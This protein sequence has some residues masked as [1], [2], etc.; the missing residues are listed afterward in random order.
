MRLTLLAAGAAAFLVTVYRAATYPFTHDESLSYGMLTWAPEW[1]STANNHPLN[2]LL[3]RACAAL[4]GSSE[5]SLRLPNVL[6]LLLY[7]TAAVLLLRR[8]EH[9]LPQL[10]GF[11]LLV[12]NPF[13]LDFFAV[14]RG[15]GLALGFL[16]ASVWL[17]VRGLEGDAWS[18]YLCVPAGALS[19]IAN[20]TFLNFFAPLLAVA[21][22]I[23]VRRK[24]FPGAIVITCAGALFLA[25]TGLEV[26]SMQQRGVLAFGGDQGIVADTLASLVECT[27]YER[28][29]S[30]RTV[31]VLVALLAAAFLALLALGVVRRSVSP[32]MLLLVIL[33]G[34]VVLPI[35][36]NRFAGTRYPIERG[37]LYLIPLF[38]LTL[39]FALRGKSALVISALIVLAGGV[40]FARTFDPRTNY[41][42]WYDAHDREVLDL[43]D[44]DRHGRNVNVGISWVFEPSLNHYRF[45]RRLTWLGQ[46]QRRPITGREDYVYVFASQAPP[47]AHTVLASY[48]DTN[49]VLLRLN[50]AQRGTPPPRPL[51]AY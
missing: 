39:L 21:L 47:G 25:W 50:A 22:W 33:G 41:T 10:A 20:F 42:W 48:A 28:P 18:L 36:G 31:A 35:A 38:A 5:L 23:L 14:A 49:T 17:L 26:R 43:V 8:L 3:L 15:Y 51:R 45:T 13:V 34:A 29:P 7:L 2:T 46:I 11:V 1:A 32:F 40:H 12:L 9:P 27:L 44:R 19:V 16:M 37:A 4:F 24:L 6:A 30:P